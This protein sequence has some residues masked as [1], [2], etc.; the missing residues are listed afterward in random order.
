MAIIFFALAFVI[1]LVI[2]VLSISWKNKE[3]RNDGW[4]RPPVTSDTGV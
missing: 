1:I 2:A 3:K 4:E